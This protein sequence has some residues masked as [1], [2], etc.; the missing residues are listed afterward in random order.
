MAGNEIMVLLRP[1]PFMY[2]TDPGVTLLEL[3]A[4]N[5]GDFGNKGSCF[6]DPFSLPST[7]LTGNPTGPLGFEPPS[8]YE[9]QAF[10]HG[11][12][13]LSQGLNPTPP[14]DLGVVDTIEKR[15]ERR[16]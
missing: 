13:F 10:V 3:L 8:N 1:A 12:P 7:P 5:Q 6:S 15:G 14:S 11:G 2:E 9:S 4:F 16:R